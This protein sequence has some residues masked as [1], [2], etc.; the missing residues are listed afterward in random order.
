MRA[1]HD[2]ARLPEALAEAKAE[3]GAAFGNATVYAERLVER[4]RHV[5]VQVLG[6]THGNV[7]HLGERECSI[8][9]RHQKIVEE[10]PSTALSP[11]M[12]AAMCDAAVRA[13][14]AVGYVGAGTVEFLVEGDRFW[15]LEMNTRIQ[16]EHPI[17]EL[18]RGVDL[19]RAQLAVALGAALPPVPEARGH[20]IECRVVAED[21]RRDWTPSPG[22]IVRWRPPSGPG[23]RV[24]AG[25]GEG[26]EVPVFYDPLLAKLIVWG[27]DRSAAIARMR[28]AL[29]EFVVLGVETN[30]EILH[31]IVAS[32]AFAAGDTRTDFLARLGWQPPEVDAAAFVAAWKAAPAPVAAAAGPAGEASPWG[33]LGRWP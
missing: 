1:V 27:E 6:D 4:P 29:A 17:T 5:E 24:D 11:E 13:A 30:L 19:V 3:A 16:V 7:V 28:R 26:S 32:E 10:T 12:R 2:A 9:R 33:T 22:T 18:V 20:A 31:D 25:V 21:P 8:Q 15:F 14:K 23:V